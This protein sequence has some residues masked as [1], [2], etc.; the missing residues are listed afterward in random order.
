MFLG[1]VVRKDRSVYKVVAYEEACYMHVHALPR[2]YTGGPFSC[3][4]LAP[5]NWQF[6]LVFR[7]FLW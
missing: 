6:L 4:L 3:P 1:C 2:V 7:W 5:R